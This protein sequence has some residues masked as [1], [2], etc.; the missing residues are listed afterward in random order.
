PRPEHAEE[1]GADGE[2]AG[3]PR[4]EDAT[5]HEAGGGRGQRG[6]GQR[7]QQRSGVIDLLGGVGAGG[8]VLRLTGEWLGLGKIRLE[9]GLAIDDRSHYLPAPTSRRKATARGA[10]G[11]ISMTWQPNA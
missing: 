11:W 9:S 4:A 10:P 8:G 1:G 5:G 2:G 6:D 7:P 3:G